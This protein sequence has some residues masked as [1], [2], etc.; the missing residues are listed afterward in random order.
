MS[1]ALF[2]NRIPPKPSAFNKVIMHYVC[3]ELFSM[4]SVT[5][6]KRNTA[7]NQTNRP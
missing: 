1:L 7:Y 5:L 4:Y 3:T 2:S 6:Q